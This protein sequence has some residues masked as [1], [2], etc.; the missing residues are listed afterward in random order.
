M[1]AG[2]VPE[3]LGWGDSSVGRVLALQ[4]QGPGFDPQHPPQKIKKAN[5]CI[6]GQLIFQPDYQDHSM[7]RN[8]LSTNGASLTGQS[9]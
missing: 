3:T 6:S 4:A 2:K 7:E 9:D 5:S 1:A 8:S